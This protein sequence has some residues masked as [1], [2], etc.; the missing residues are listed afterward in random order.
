MLRE[1]L[2]L[3]LPE[4]REWILDR[5]GE[6]ARRTG[7]EPLVCAPLLLPEPRFF[8]DLWSPD[9]D[10]ARRLARRLQRYAGL[11][12]LGVDI[13]LSARH[14]EPPRHGVVPH[15]VRHD[16][17]AAY[18]AGIVDGVC[19][20]EI[21][22]EQLRDGLGVTAALTHEVAHAFRA[23][24]GL[25]ITDSAR[26]DEE[27][28]LTDL[29]TIYLGAGVIT[30]NG[31]ARHRSEL[32]PASM[33]Y[34]LA[35]VAVVRGLGRS[36]RWELVAQLELDQAASF[37]RVFAQLESQ[38][39]KLRAQLGVPLD[40][41]AWPTAWSL[42][43]LT[44]PIED[45]EPL[46]SN[47]EDADDDDAA[48]DEPP[49]NL[50]RS[51]Y[52]VLPGYQAG[53]NLLASLLASG[54][55]VVAAEIDVLLGTFIGVFGFFVAPLAIRKL[56]AERCSDSQCKTRLPRAVMTCPNCGGTIAGAIRGRQ[57]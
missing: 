29:T 52:R 23:R 56:G 35:V 1:M 37:K 44:A 18:F 48:A 11:D 39:S 2:E 33:V 12:D 55:G 3:P 10:G 9:V 53:D 20:F 7:W 8:P 22:V 32:S 16:G 45:S 17:A 30:T 42:D 47:D 34:A 14:G 46:Q 49:W 5:L 28:R 36:A 50:G 24:F 27:E 51:V 54:V 4:E 31:A 43:E 15:S 6:L 19:V 41:A 26:I 13:E 38:C 25:A 21:D 57:R 40:A